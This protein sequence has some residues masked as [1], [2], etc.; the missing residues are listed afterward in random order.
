MNLPFLDERGSSS[1]LS[2][3][4]SAS[5]PCSSWWQSVRM[6]VTGEMGQCVDSL[7]GIPISGE[8]INMYHVN[9]G[10]PRQDSRLEKGL[11]FWRDAKVPVDVV[12]IAGL[13]DKPKGFDSCFMIECVG[14]ASGL[15]L[16]WNS[17]TD[18]TMKF[19]SKSQIEVEVYCG[20]SRGLW[21]FIGEEF[22]S[23]VGYERL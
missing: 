2:T 9:N 12:F 14:R 20:D 6:E 22:F 16:L 13:H 21:R 17:D 11:G 4:E 8:V 1:S 10:A 23:F 15:A 3:I 5:Q 18:V 19:Y 7:R